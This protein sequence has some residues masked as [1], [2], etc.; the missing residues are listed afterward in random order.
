MI[1]EKGYEKNKVNILLTKENI[2]ELSSQYP[3]IF[4]TLFGNNPDFT[5]PVRYNS[6][7]DGT[8]NYVNTIISSHFDTSDPLGGSKFLG[9]NDRDVDFWRF[10]ETSLKILSPRIFLKD[11]DREILLERGV[12]ANAI[13]DKES[14][15]YYSVEAR[16]NLNITRLGDVDPE[17]DVIVIREKGKLSFGVVESSSAP[18]PVV[19]SSTIIL[20]RE[21]PDQE[22]TLWTMHP[23]DPIR[24]SNLDTLPG[25]E[26]LC[27]K[28][29]QE[30][31]D[32]F[33]VP[34]SYLTEFLGPDK[35]I[36]VLGR[37]PSNPV[38]L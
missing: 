12:P 19:N 38:S 34:A 18:R 25:F 22:Y 31:V 14:V 9:S 35:Y 6:S 30:K 13:Y 23:G 20:G 21:N 15:L 11:D 10:F 32:Y 24:P 17:T 4:R 16:G 27:S 8:I 28:L 7:M 2:S 37:R 33:T 1:K 5:I 26:S 29:V 3:N 36:K